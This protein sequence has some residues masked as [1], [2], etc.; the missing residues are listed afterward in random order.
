[1]KISISHT[2]PRQLAAFQYHSALHP[3][4]PGAGFQIGYQYKVSNPKKE[5]YYVDNQRVEQ[6]MV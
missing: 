5:S 1:V 2:I 4:V 3:C 6:Y